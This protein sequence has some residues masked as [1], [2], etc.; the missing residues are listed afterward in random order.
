[1]AVTTKETDDPREWG[2]MK[3]P[4]LL[5]LRADQDA[6]ERRLEE[7]GDEH[8][9]KLNADAARSSHW[10]TL[11]L[12]AAGGATPADLKRAEQN[13]TAAEFEHQRGEGEA[14]LLREKQSRLREDAINAVSRAQ[15]K[16]RQRYRSAYGSTAKAFASALF[17]ARQHQL[18]LEAIFNAARDSFLWG[19][20][21][22]QQHGEAAG[23]GGGHGCG[24]HM[25]LSALLP[26]DSR[27]RTGALEAFCTE[28][29][30]I[31]S[32][33]EMETK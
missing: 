27:P 11:A 18:R 25:I 9:R 5:K 29:E 3:D 33:A 22:A 8:G 2:W 23:I 12:L 1:M 20:K 15:A 7:L 6:V 21:E 24:P 17:D 28:V 19:S 13:A 16:S 32:P 10:R 31:F 4:A 26:A 30:R 14:I